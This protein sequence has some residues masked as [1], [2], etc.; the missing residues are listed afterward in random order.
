ME[1]WSSELPVY[2]MQRLAAGQWLVQDRDG[3]GPAVRTAVVIE[4]S[5]IAWAVPV[6]VA[7]AVTDGGISKAVELAYRCRNIRGRP[8]I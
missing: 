6:G 8:W 1:F 7:A 4:K 3:C 5:A 2:A